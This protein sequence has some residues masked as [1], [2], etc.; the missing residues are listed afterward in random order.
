LVDTGAGSS[1]VDEQYV[2][3]NKM[4]INRIAETADHA[5]TIADKSTIKV[6]GNAHI[7]LTIGN[8]IFDHSFYVIS[9]LSVDII[10]GNDFQEMN[11]A[12]IHRGEK[13]FSLLNG[14]IQVPLCIRGP[15]QI[16][17]ITPNKITIPL[18]SQQVLQVQFPF[19]K[20]N[21]V[22]MLEPLDNQNAVGFR[23]AQCIWQKIL[24]SLK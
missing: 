11:D 20:T 12:I 4:T 21:K 10:L 7:E 13:T 23:V 19:C 5:F 22:L 2:R 8:E 3:D 17:A 9:N 6:L 1:C 15:P 16:M 18:N 24:L 14:M